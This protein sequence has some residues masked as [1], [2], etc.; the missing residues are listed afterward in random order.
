MTDQPDIRNLVGADVPEPELERLRRADELLRAADRPPEVPESLTARVLAIP[1]SRPFR[2]YRVVAGIAAAAALA[3]VTFAVGTWVGGEDPPPVAEEITLNATAQAPR[4]AWMTMDVFPK[5]PAGNWTILAEAGGLPP[6]PQGSYYEVW[7]TRN[8][9][10]ASPC[11][12]FVVDGTGA[13]QG[14]WLNAPYEFEEYDRWVVVAVLPGQAPSRWLL[15]GPV[16]T[17]A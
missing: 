9:K 10:L 6:L 14:F 13:A 4:E 7:M 11:G 8:D 2:R 17:P 3:G 1:G 12:R 5:D 16:T 15:D